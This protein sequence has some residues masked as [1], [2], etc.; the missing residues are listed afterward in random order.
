MEIHSFDDD[1]DDVNRYAD[2][3]A[4]AVSTLALRGFADA[5]Q[6]LRPIAGE[7]WMGRLQSKGRSGDGGGAAGPRVTDEALRAQVFVR[8]RFRCTSCGQRAIPR[9]ILVALHDLFPA[10]IPYHAH[11]ARGKVHPVFWALAPEADHKLAHS[12]GGLNVLENLTTLHAACNTQKSDSLEAH[13]RRNETP[14]VHGE[15]DGLVSHYP[16]LIAAGAGA[17]RPAYHRAWSRRYAAL[18]A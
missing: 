13:M 12:R 9:S 8:D 3:L 14:R 15:W 1:D 10:E 4:R 7:V 16:L 5:A 2:T 17:S 11:Y 6:E 18:S